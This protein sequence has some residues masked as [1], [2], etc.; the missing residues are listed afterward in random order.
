[1]IIQTDKQYRKDEFLYTIPGITNK[2]R[3]RKITIIFI[4]GK[5]SKVN[6]PLPGILSR[7]DWK[8]LAE[9]DSEIIKI[10]EHFTSNAETSS[11]NSVKED[12]VLLDVEKLVTNNEKEKEESAGCKS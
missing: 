3:D 6:T 4:N 11:L 5:F 8:I 10:E 1:M 7:R 2:T 12:T 9:I